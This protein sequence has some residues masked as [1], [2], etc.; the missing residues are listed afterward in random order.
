MES[1]VCRSGRT[2]SGRAAGLRQAAALLL[3]EADRVE[4]VAT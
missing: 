1:P 3:A 2:G 4:A